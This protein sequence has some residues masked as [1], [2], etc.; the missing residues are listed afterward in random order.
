M[1]ALVDFD[2]RFVDEAW[3][4]YK[5]NVRNPYAKDFLQLVAKAMGK[6]NKIYPRLVFF[7]YE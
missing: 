6:P 7:N 3:E 4:F 2:H 1:Y 5:T